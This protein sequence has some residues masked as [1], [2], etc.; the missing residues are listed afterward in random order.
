MRLQ[1]I[2]VIFTIFISSF[3][4]S[5]VFADEETF[6]YF[7]DKVWYQPRDVIQIS[8]WVNIQNY[9]E[10]VV[11][12]INPDNILIKNETIPLDDH[13]IDH[14]IPT[15]GQEWEKPG[16]Y[17]IRITVG[18]ETQTRYFGFG[19]FNPFEY[20]PEISFDKENYSW[21]D[22]VK[23][24]VLSP[25]DN[26]ANNKLDK[27]K[28]DISSNAGKLSSYVLEETG[29][30]YGVFS[31]LVTLTGHSDYDVNGDRRKGD[32]EG[33]T[34]GSG[35]EE[36]YLSVYPND[37][38][39]VT[40]SPN[41]FEKSIE[42]TIPVQ[43]QLGK[44]MWLDK[45]EPGK[46]SHIRVIDKDMSLHSQFRDRVSVL[47]GISPGYSLK[48]F[49]LE[50]IGD[51][52]GIFEGSVKFAKNQDDDGILISN[53]NE[54]FAK[55]IDRTLPSFYSEKSLEVISKQTSFGAPQGGLSSNEDF[56][57]DKTTCLTQKETFQKNDSDIYL[58]NHWPVKGEW[59]L[60]GY[61]EMNTT[62]IGDI[63][64]LSKLPLTDIKIN[65]KTFRGG[66]LLEEESSWYPI[67]KILRPNEASPFV[68][69]PKLTGFD[70]YQI[71]IKD[72]S[73]SCD[74][75]T[76]P[77]STIDKIVIGDVGINQQ[78]LTIFC[79]PTLPT[80][81]IGK[82]HFILVLYNEN[83]YI[84]SIETG[85][86]F[87]SSRYGCFKEGSVDITS[88][89]D[90]FKKNRLEI[91]VIG[92]PNTLVFS[93]NDT[94][95]QNLI[96]TNEYSTYYPNS[97]HPKYMNIE[98][99]KIKAEQSEKI[100]T[101]TRTPKILD[102]DE[103]AIDSLNLQGY[104]ALKAGKYWDAISWFDNAL[105]HDPNNTE[106]LFNK[107]V[108]LEALGFDDDAQA[109]YDK[110]KQL[111]SPLNIPKWIKENAKWWAQ[112]SI[113]D[114]DFV[115]GIQF[116]IKEEIMTIPKTKQG[117]ILNDSQTIPSWV[118]NNAKWWANGLISDDDF[119]KGIQYLVEQ[120]IILI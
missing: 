56:G 16:F 70:T 78:T 51:N 26:K 64:N 114:S 77:Q 60:K 19:N 84:D 5:L 103:M 7:L 36:G 31:G 75:I 80:R 30:S 53:G 12:T 79:N 23:I 81:D 28:V 57:F 73:V 39:K 25:V 113:K 101:P 18:N 3:V 63:V 119:V 44:V 115:S 97:L 15:L 42:K 11:E 90:F 61:E 27:I 37:Q 35:P 48:E 88:L 112:G 91:F 29:L 111:E 41:Y 47:V 38:I 105:I 59:Y 33:L 32:A 99:L 69:T 8:G 20:K 100:Q 96:Q 108:A 74:R 4:T 1:F 109:L 10:I 43:F 71:W 104:F 58:V 65:V 2:F 76:N 68:I 93:E 24:T 17:L 72:Y 6:S 83:F 86:S 9:S 46:R 45:I 92:G 94:Q 89:I 22:T 13:E 95:F 118:K 107:G 14:T 55:Y 106:A 67:K 52:N 21:T 66:Q 34:Y 98:D 54:V 117:A 110:V 50:E 116:L 62:I 102:S 40:Y 120:G 82:Q 87:F 85:Q 49:E